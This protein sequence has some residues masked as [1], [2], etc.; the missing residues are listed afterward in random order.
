[1]TVPARAF[2]AWLDQEA[3]HL[4]HAAVCRAAGIKRSTLAQQFVRGRVTISTVA[5]VSRSLRQPV[6]ETLSK[7]ETYADLRAGV[8]RPTDAELL[9]QVSD[10]DLLAEIL[11]RKAQP[12]G[13]QPPTPPE[14]A[15]IPHQDSVRAWMDAIG[16]SEF[17]RRV[18]S[19]AG[20]APQNLSAQ[21]SANRLN[22]EI[23]IKAARLANVGVTNGLV[24]AGFITPE[25]AGWAP[26]SRREVLS[27]TATSVLA[28]L[29]SDRM[30]ALSRSLR[31][32]EQDSSAEQ[33]LWENLG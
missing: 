11:H 10:L 12:L 9:S 2:Q 14:L 1:M 24:V 8:L 29:A 25:E 5:A 15:P 6:V 32:T 13:V 31:R 18:A 22:A 19:D 26:A 33:A 20:I 23:A 30:E 27:R 17:R 4:S 16:D 21:I 28:G 7:F 3:S